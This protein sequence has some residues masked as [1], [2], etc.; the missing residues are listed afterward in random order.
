MAKIKLSEGFKPLPEGTYVLK[1]TKVN[2]KEDCGKLDG[3][4]WY[5]K[6]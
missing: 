3:Y 6:K 5:R 2:Y 1:I 4:C